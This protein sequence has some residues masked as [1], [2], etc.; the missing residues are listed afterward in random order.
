M[1]AYLNPWLAVPSE[2]PYLLFCDFEIIRAYNATHQ[3]KKYQVQD[4][5]LPEPFVGVTTAPVILR[6]L[7]PGFNDQDPEVHSRPEFQALL[8]NNYCH[9]SSAFP[10]YFLNPGFECSGRRWWERLLRWLLEKFSPKE[11]A[12]SILC[13]EYFP[14]H[15]RNFNHASLRLPSQEYG[16]SLV[17]SAIARGSVVVIMRAE[18]YWKASVPELEGY[19]RALRLNSRQNVSVSPSRKLSG[20]RSVLT[21]PACGRWLHHL[22]SQE[23]ATQHFQKIEIA[24]PDCVH[25]FTFPSNR[26][27]NRPASSTILPYLRHS[28]LLQP[29][30]FFLLP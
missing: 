15:S 28:L 16:F 2:P 6:G 29:R 20:C 30:P 12:R 27:A 3:N 17:R 25:C 18:R 5:V 14:Y 8:R 4:T 7:N 9:A 1:A 10:F 26:G 22:S 13:V 24:A 21:L 11:L 23:L 19:S